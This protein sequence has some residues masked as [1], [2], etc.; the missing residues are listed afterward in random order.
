MIAL[1]IFI[2]NIK[3]VFL[4]AKH[5]TLLITNYMMVLVLILI[6][7]RNYGDKTCLKN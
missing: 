5:L 2:T 1:R 4:V 7:R 3:A 6:P